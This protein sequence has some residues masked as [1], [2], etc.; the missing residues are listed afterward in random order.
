VDFFLIRIC[1]KRDA[2]LHNPYDHADL[3]CVLACTASDLDVVTFSE[4]FPQLFHGGIN[5]LSLHRST[6]DL[7]RHDIASDSDSLAR[8]AL[9]L[10]FEDL[11]LVARKVVSSSSS[12]QRRRDRRQVQ[13]LITTFII[14]RKLRC[15]FQAWIRILKLYV[16]ELECLDEETIVV[17]CTSKLPCLAGGK[18]TTIVL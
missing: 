7:K 17:K 16:A 3:I 5:L 11:D 6:R 14:H 4:Q 1:D 8:N 12:L 15:L 10:A 13:I 9:L 2:F 18:A